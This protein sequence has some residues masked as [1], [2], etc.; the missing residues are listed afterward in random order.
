[1]QDLLQREADIAVRMT[2][3][4]Q[5]Q[6]IARRI[7]AVPLGLHAHKRYLDTHGT[8]ASLADLAQHALI[9][10]DE[11]SPFVRAARK[12]FPLWNRDNFAVRTDSDMA[13][14]AMIRAGCG[15]G[16]CQVNL[17]ARDPNLVNILPGS[18]P[19][20]LETWLTMHEDLRNNPRCKV[21]FD[22]LV[23]GL[24]DYITS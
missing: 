24:Q 11:E 16:V 15:I 10:F 5:E 17:A 13:Q 19:L 8:P 22:A 20:G 23:K 3:P 4:M 14:M 2:Q 9:G 1:V 7:G 18:I 21:T 6:L 12:D